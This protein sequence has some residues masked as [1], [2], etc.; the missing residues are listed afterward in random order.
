ME[1][2]DIHTKS[3]TNINLSVVIDCIDLPNVTCMYKEW[4]PS[5]QD[6]WNT[7]PQ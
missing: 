7:V 1:G 4:N 6:T 2:E 3:F 5:N